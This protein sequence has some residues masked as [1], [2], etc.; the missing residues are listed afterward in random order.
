[1]WG[2]NDLE[3]AELRLEK[4]AGGKRNRIWALKC[5]LI[6]E[7]IPTAPKTLP[8]APARAVNGVL[9]AR[10]RR[11]L[12]RDHQQHLRQHGGKRGRLRGGE[13]RRASAGPSPQ[14][15]GVT[16]DPETRKG[17]DEGIAQT[18]ACET[19]NIL[20]DGLLLSLSS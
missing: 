18:Q 12:G 3:T 8:S 1:M 10:S 17:K 15:G 11:Q 6:Y 19:E 5:P 9:T 13:E 16:P 14:T 4:Y 20:R 2:Q 7:S